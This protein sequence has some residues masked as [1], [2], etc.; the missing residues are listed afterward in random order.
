MM[1]DYDTDD[2]FNCVNHEQ[3]ITILKHFKFQDHLIGTIKDFNTDRSVH[4]AFDGKEEDSASFN[5]GVPQRSPI[6]PVL[7]VIYAAAL[8]TPR[9]TQ[10]HH[11]TT[12][13]VD[14]E[15]MLQEAP[16]KKE[17]PEAYKPA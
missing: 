5:L 3:L 8:S 17:T 7:F 13:Y 6:S 2:A 14:D 11:E 15:I 1:M 4:L 16:T 12:S 9:Q 10:S